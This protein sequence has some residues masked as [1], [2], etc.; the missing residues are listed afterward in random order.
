ML[1]NELI[2]CTGMGYMKDV[3]QK[4]K[5]GKNDTNAISIPVELIPS[6]M[7]LFLPELELCMA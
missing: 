2:Q 5:W 1:Y 6:F 7:F 4:E 3:G